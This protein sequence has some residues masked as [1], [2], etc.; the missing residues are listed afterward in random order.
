[1]GS[2]SKPQEL[3][4]EKAKKREKKKLPRRNDSQPDQPLTPA[5]RQV[6]DVVHDLEKKLCMQQ[7]EYVRKQI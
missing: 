4:F 2:W 6:S 7:E 1:V 3:P 5:R